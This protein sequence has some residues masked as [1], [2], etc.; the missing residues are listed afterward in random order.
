[1]SLED[2]FPVKC[3]GYEKFGFKKGA[4]LRKDKANIKVIGFLEDFTL[5]RKQIE[6]EIGRI[7]DTENQA[8]E[9]VPK[10]AQTLQ[11]TLTV[12]IKQD[13]LIRSVIKNP[14]VYAE[15]MIFTEPAIYQDGRQCFD[16]LTYTGKTR[17]IVCAPLIVLKSRQV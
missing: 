1:M 16:P 15:G 8:V 4:K 7:D 14:K 9:Y 6:I 13:N 5:P 11:Y 10:H 17:V 2:I 12:A 3:K